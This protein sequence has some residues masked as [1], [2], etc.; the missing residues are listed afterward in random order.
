MI[1]PTKPRRVVFLGFRRGGSSIVFQS[2][3]HIFNNS[4]YRVHDLVAEKYI[5][6]DGRAPTAADLENA[7]AENDVVGCFREPPPAD[8]D[9]SEFDVKYILLVRDPRDCDYSWWYARNI[10]K[11]DFK[12]YDNI[13][14]YFRGENFY[15]FEGLVDYAERKSA[16]IFKYEEAFLNPTKFIHDIISETG[17]SYDVGA[18]DVANIFMAMSNL[19]GSIKS[20]NRSGLPFQ[21]VN[22]LPEKSLEILNNKYGRLLQRLG[23]SIE[24]DASLDSC[25]ASRF[26]IDSLK[27]TIKVLM[28]QNH[29]RAQE[30]SEAFRAASDA[31]QKYI[32]AMDILRVLS[33]RVSDLMK[34]VNDL[35]TENHYR[36]G[37]LRNLDEEVVQ[38]K[39]LINDFDS[40]RSNSS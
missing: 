34:T 35:S 6:H 10:H 37:H 19:G 26:E 36:I 27:R 28:D 20:H 24:K 16:K 12:S 39:N 18:F 25:V 14:D 15:Q 2:I 29:F 32:E 38:I 23:Y 7:L 13:D 40:H 11:P 17:F 3:Q 1:S 21:A 22:I 9:L 33:D 30:T 8:A 31:N 4:G 5:G